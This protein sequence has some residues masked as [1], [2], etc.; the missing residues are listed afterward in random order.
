MNS[1]ELFD[2]I[3]L[4]RADG[5]CECEG[6]CG[7][8]HRFG[9]HTRCGNT[10]GRPA[11]HGADKMV[12]LTVTPRDGDPRNLDGRNL[13]AFCQACLKRHRAKLKAAA[14]KAAARAAAD[15][16]DGG[17]FDMPDA[18]AAAGNGITL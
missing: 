18:P 8:S 16:A 4:T 12:S 13:I 2:R 1:A 11:T 14:D 6:A 7:S 9:G 15:A 5:R 3:A 17:L 10:H